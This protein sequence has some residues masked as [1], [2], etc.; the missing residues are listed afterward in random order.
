M[1]HTAKRME[2]L[3]PHF[4]ATLSAK[5]RTMSAQG[6]DV[7]R[8]DEGSPDLP[9]A[10]HII[11]ALAQSAARSSSHAYQPHAGTPAVRRAW[12]EMYRWVHG[13][14]LDPDHEVVLL[15][16]SKEGIFH[17]MQA[18][19][20]PGDVVLIP[21]P[22]YITYTRGT[23]F[24][25][26][27]P[28]YLPLRPEAGYLPDLEAIPMEV[29]GRAKMMW[30]NYPNNPTSAMATREFFVQAVDFAREHNILLC[31][32]AAYAQVT[33]D[34]A[35]APSL[36]EIPGA[37]DVALEYNTLSKSHNMAGWRV[38][39]VVGN[40][41]A[42]RSLF[43][44]KT[45]LDSSQFLPILDA[46]TA[47]MT[48]DQ[49]WLRERNETY[50]Q[51]RDVVVRALHAMG[52]RAET[53]KG[54][55]YVWSPIPPETTSVEFVTWLLDQAHLSLTPGTVFGK[56]GEGFI[57]ISITAPIDRVQLGME[58]MQQALQEGW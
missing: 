24:V 42:L 14:E 57:R 50:R 39:T 27:E 44:L 58:R 8:L 28:F 9:P 2:H 36:L 37:R 30:L 32:D 5:L 31:H 17:A 3:A 40:P 26:G 33:Y 23:L 1:I 46:A 55:L 56:G 18:F 51:R 13:V 10:P 38:G 4:F 35:Y 47:A 52:L 49:S 53:P 20:D 43:T 6:I 34:G 25:G 16:G 21:D 48:G 12:A 41:Q 45:N 22:G 19:I 29:R 11:D 15:L 7:V 54:S